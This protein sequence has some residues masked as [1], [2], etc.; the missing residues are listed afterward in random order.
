MRLKQP[1]ASLGVL[2]LLA[3]CG[4]DGT[5]PRIAD[6]TANAADAKAAAV[7]ETD[8]TANTDEEIIVAYQDNR[9][10]RNKDLEVKIYDGT[11]VPPAT[12]LATIG[13]LRPGQNVIACTGSLIRANIVLTAAHCVCGGVNGR[14]YVGTDPAF[15][16][17]P[18]SGRYY[19]IAASEPALSCKKY[20]DAKAQGSGSSVL[21]QY[22]DLA[23][24]KLARRV[25]NSVTP[26]SI[27]GDA[28]VANAT[29]F[30]VIGFGAIDRDGRV[31][32]TEKRE[33][34]VT[35]VS[36]DCRGNRDGQAD[37]DYYGC[38]PGEEIVAG[39]RRSPDTCNGDSGGPL[40]TTAQGTSGSGAREHYVL[41][42]VTSR[43]IQNSPRA[44][45][46][47]G[48]YERLTPASRNWIDATL[49]KLGAG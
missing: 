2:L 17:G 46:Y 29:S 41:A 45:G 33:A 40:L 8:R 1:S 42:G 36:N 30:R 26:L 4:Q 21:R 38:Q 44:C 43:P 14:V 27:A 7:G 10:R 25:P 13:I 34:S 16:S 6:N 28:L 47:G 11:P 35:A 22:A 31:Y 49:R 19:D 20:Q 48:L 37:G 23:V 15:P 32:R 3:A 39:Q 12:Y 9:A 24:L 18:S 5:R